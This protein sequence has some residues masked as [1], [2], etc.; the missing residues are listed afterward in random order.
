MTAVAVTLCFIQ[1][2]INATIAAVL[3][4]RVSLVRRKA[5]AGPASSA[6]TMSDQTVSDYSAVRHGALHLTPEHSAVP[7]TLCMVRTTA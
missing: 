1:N 3:A 2:R 6:K 4:D 7:A 5:L